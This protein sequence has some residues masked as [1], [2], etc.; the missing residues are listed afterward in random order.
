MPASPAAALAVQ[1]VQP[2]FPFL[3]LKAQFASIREEVSA[4]VMQVLTAQHFIMGPEVSSFEEEIKPVVGCQYTVACASGS[5]ALLLVL[6]ALDIGP[7]D[8]VIT[9]PFTFV[10]TAGCIA[11]L[12]A[13]PVFIDIDPY[14]YNLDPAQLNRAI[15]KHTKAIIPIHLFW[16][17][18][19]DGSHPADCGQTEYTRH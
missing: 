6:M 1:P 11:R 19:R 15:T 18:G 4:A 13:R 3:D 14:S 12:G 17:S 2:L 9:V 16:T 7:G 5:D 8:E 10:A